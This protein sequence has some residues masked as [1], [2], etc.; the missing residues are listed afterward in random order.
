MRSMDERRWG[1]AL[2]AST[3]V[4]GLLAAG[5]AEANMGGRGHLVV[6]AERLFGWYIYERNWKFDN[7]PDS[8]E[9]TSSIGLLFQ[10]PVGPLVIPRLS[11]DYFLTDE[12]SVGGVFGYYHASSER[13]NDTTRFN[14]VLFSPRIGYRFGFTREFGF[15]PRAGLTYFG[16][17]FPQDRNQLAFS[18]DAPFYFAPDPRFG[19]LLGPIVE[20]GFMGS[21]EA[22]GEDPSYRERVFGLTT[23]L[24]LRF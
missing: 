20:F 21:Q 17:D 15:W 4:S 8:E 11:F 13:D 19:F 12:I 23:G 9:S 14:A 10:Q 2:A 18:L 5:T 1:C 3:L 6:G 16:G 7:L 22:P 24:F